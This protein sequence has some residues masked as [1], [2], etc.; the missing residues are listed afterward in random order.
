MFSKS[1]Q[2]HVSNQKLVDTCRIA[3]KV[4]DNKNLVSDNQILVETC[5]ITKNL[6]ERC[7]TSER[8]QRVPQRLSELLKHGLILSTEYS[9]YR[10]L[11]GRTF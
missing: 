3:R 1:N 7:W 10:C 2:H 8:R 4:S 5:R 9:G 11:E 6:V